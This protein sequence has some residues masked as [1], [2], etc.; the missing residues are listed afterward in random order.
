MS[1][2]KTFPQ[3]EREISG[4]TPAFGWRF[5]AAEEHGTLAELQAAG[6][7]D[8]QATHEDLFWIRHRVG[9]QILLDMR[10]LE[11]D[12]RELMHSKVYW[13][14]LRRLWL[15]WDMFWLTSSVEALTAVAE[16]EQY[17]EAQRE[18]HRERLSQVQTLAHY[19]DAALFS[20]PAAPIPPRLG[21]AGSGAQG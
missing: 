19:E 10:M 15:R 4:E 17:T 21:T 11:A 16:R 6:S 2:L 13:L 9:E 1:R 20:V 3:I 7:L 14:W 8:R 5:D 18:Q 12:R